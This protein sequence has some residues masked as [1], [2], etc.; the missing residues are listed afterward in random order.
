MMNEGHSSGSRMKW[1]FLRKISWHFFLAAIVGPFLVCLML[2]VSRFFHQIRPENLGHLIVQAVT[3]MVLVAPM[4]FV[5]AVVSFIPLA[6][7]SKIR[8]PRSRIIAFSV[9]GALLG[10]PVGIWLAYS[11][12]GDPSNWTWMNWAWVLGCVCIGAVCG[13][14]DSLAWRDGYSRATKS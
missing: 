12:Q 13:L 14:L 1:P 4:I 11:G 8:V 2:F 10:L 5:F 3:A 6:A 7:V 9:A